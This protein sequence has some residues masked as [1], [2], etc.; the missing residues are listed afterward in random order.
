MIKYNF[1]RNIHNL[2]DLFNAPK[3][4]SQLMSQGKKYSIQVVQ[5]DD[6]WMAKI[7]RKVTTKRTKVTKKKGRFTTETEAQA[8]AEAELKTLVEQLKR[9]NRTG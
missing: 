9:Q 3:K 5:N 8:W 7:I 6:A 1:P 4:G 2:L